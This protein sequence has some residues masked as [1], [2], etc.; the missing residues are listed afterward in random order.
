MTEPEYIPKMSD[1]DPHV[2]S[3]Q[4]CRERKRQGDAAGKRGKDAIKIDGIR[5]AAA[6]D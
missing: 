5:R 6:A 1:A 4:S 3:V 2:R